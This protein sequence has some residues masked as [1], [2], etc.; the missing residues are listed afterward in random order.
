M[1]PEPRGGA[2]IEEG[3]RAVPEG[4]V[5]ARLLH[6]DSVS[7]AMRR[8]RLI[9][10]DDSPLATLFSAYFHQDWMLEGPDARAVLEKFIAEV[11]PDEIREAKEQAEALLTALNERQLARTVR[12]MGLYY[13]PQADGLTYRDWLVSVA[14][15]LGSAM[16]NQP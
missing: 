6:S 3:V 10:Y 14:E 15:T 5:E 1:A 9:P 12:R 16:P 7:G 13:L 4:A 11:E 8:G 2:Q